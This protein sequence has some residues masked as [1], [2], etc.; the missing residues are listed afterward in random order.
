MNHASQGT[1]AGFGER[2]QVSFEDIPTDIEGF[3]EWGTRLDPDHPYKYELSNGKVS[4]MMIQAS[5]KHWEVTANILDQLLPR[6]DRKRFRAGP[7][8]FGVRTGVGVRYPD[9]VVDRASSTLEGLACEEPIF[10]VEVLSPS[11]AGLDFTLK[12]REYSAIETVQTYLI[13]SQDE[14]RAWV[15]Q[16]QPNVAWPELPVELAG[17]EGKIALGEFGI[18]LAMADIF[19]DIPDPPTLR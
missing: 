14:P 9:I 7:T 13:C 2:G 19:L 12:L 15:W 16:R 11:T 8:E 4:R 3:L 18:E 1:T 6:L 17:R 5:R 10:I